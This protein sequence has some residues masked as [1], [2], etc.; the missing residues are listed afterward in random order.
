M[1]YPKL[2]IP[3]CDPF[4]YGGYFFWTNILSDNFVA[5]VSFFIL[6]CQQIYP[7]LL[8]YWHR[9]I[10]RDKTSTGFYRQNYFEHQS[11]IEKHQKTF[12]SVDLKTIFIA[13][14]KGQ[15]LFP[16]I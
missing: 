1:K 12:L 9:D 11:K 16:P 10:F 4:F 7:H 5:L 3:T 6:S 8:I 13:A 14:E 2:V 15:C